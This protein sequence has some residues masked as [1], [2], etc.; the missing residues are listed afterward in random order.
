MPLF[1][2]RQRAVD[3]L[4]ISKLNQSL[5]CRLILQ[6]I[7]KESFPPGYEPMIVS[8]KELAT[9]PVPGV[10]VILRSHLDF[11]GMTDVATRQIMKQESFN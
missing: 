3:A 5:C 9:D 8:S 2:D 4:Y 11:C 7:P 10:E 6:D 1:Q